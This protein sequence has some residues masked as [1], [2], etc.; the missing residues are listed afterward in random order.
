M[1]VFLWFTNILSGIVIM[2]SLILIILGNQPCSGDCCMI[3]LL[4]IIGFPML[5]LSGIIFYFTMKKTWMQKL[6]D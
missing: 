3:H 1:K 4:Y 6:N 5:I 2:F